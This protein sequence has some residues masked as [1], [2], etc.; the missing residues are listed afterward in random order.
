MPAIE[1]RDLNDKAL[2]WE[3]TG[4]FDGNSDPVVASTFVEI[5]VRWNDKQAD[6]LDPAGNKVRVDAMVIAAQDIPVFSVL[7]P[8]SQEDLEDE[9]YGTGS[10]FDDT[11]VPS[12]GLV[13]VVA[14][15][16]TR[17]L[18]GRNTRYEFGVKRYSGTLTQ[19]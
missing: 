2:L 11:L 8:G 1:V 15:N 3:H 13:R 17:D 6:M 14:D 10:I 19:G 18:K 16:T 12:E 4:G 5:A 9:L 7:W